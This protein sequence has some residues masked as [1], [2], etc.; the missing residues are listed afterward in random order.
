VAY[1]QIIYVVASGLIAVIC[2]SY[3]VNFRSKWEN[4]GQTTNTRGTFAGDKCWLP[5]SGYAS[6]L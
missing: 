1:S 2:P 5:L 6:F 3:L 4:L